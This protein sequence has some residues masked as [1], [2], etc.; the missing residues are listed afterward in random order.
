MSDYSSKTSSISPIPQVPSASGECGVSWVGSPEIDFLCLFYPFFRLGRP[1][2]VLKL[3]CFVTNDWARLHG[4]CGLLFAFF[5]LRPSIIGP[6]KFYD[7]AIFFVT[8]VFFLAEPS[9]P[10]APAG[11]DPFRMISISRSNSRRCFSYISCFRWTYFAIY[12]TWYAG[13]LESKICLYTLIL[14]F[15]SFKFW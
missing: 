9:P 4:F 13:I 10:S 11:F 8:P 14:E 15:R 2:T 12:A 1:Y 6:L 5:T 3:G 7:V